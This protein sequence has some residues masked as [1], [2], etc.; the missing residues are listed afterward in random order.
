MK[1]LKKFWMHLEY[2]IKMEK[3]SSQERF[4]RLVTNVGDEMC[5]RQLRDIGDGLGR[6]RHQHPLSLNILS[7][8]V[9]NIEIVLPI[10]ANC[11]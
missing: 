11:H 2:L 1:H 7:K 9:T 3:D 4:R 8:D 10:P 5:W 6:F